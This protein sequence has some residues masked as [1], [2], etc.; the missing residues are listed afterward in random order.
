MTSFGNRF[1]K[2]QAELVAP[3]MWNNIKNIKIIII[4]TPTI[5]TSVVVGIALYWPGRGFKNYNIRGGDSPSLE[6]GDRLPT[7]QTAAVGERRRGAAA[8][9]SAGRCRGKT[10]RIG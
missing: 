10:V 9:P 2:N 5:T 3:L 8:I 1:L 4:S 6:N 7:H